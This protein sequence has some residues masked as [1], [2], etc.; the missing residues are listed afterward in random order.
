MNSKKPEN[1]T[2]KY[3]NGI[4]TSKNGF[5]GSGL[6]CPRGTRLY[7]T[8][9]SVIQPIFFTPNIEPGEE[10][11]ILS[12]DAAPDVLPYYA[13]SNYGHLVNIK[14]VKMMKENY[15]PSG[16]GYF[17]L[18]AENSSNGQK[19]YMT[20]R[21]VMKTFD[22]RDN[23]DELEVN[24]K[25]DK[26][27]E[28]YYNK[29]MPDGTIRSNLEWSSPS[30]N[31]KHSRSTGLNNGSCLSF[32]QAS[33]IRQLHLEGYSY[34]KIVSDYY[35]GVSATCIQRICTNKSY[36]D[37]NYTPVSQDEIYNSGNNNFKIT[38]KDATIIRNL[39]NAGFKYDQIRDQFYPQISK[40]TISNIIN[41]KT[42]NR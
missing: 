20:H 30:E 16:Y 13:I 34:Q 32:E 17:C 24:Y 38:D 23:A 40:G 42:H 36:Y 21:M 12:T 41:R 2:G 14:S 37:P 19:K 29:L 5:S 6:N 3:V 4:Y 7:D 9:G 18:A 31:R 27:N 33:N 39:Y 26:K 25:N 1:D 35:P 15:K 22:P 11:R 10:Y 28:N 8:N